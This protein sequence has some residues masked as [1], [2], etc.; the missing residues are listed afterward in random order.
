MSRTRALAATLAL[1]CAAPLAGEAQAWPFG[2]KADKPATEQP[3]AA[4]PDKTSR[5][6]GVYAGEPASPPSTPRKASPEE[7]AAAARLDP[8][9]QAAFWAREMQV[10]PADADAGVRLSAALRSLG[11]H[12]GAAST[13]EQVLAARPGHAPAL[14]ELARAKLAANQGF[15][16]I[17]PLRQIRAQAPT[18]W[19]ALNLLGVAM[20]QAQRMGEAR[21]AWAEALR[22]SP[23]NPQVLTNM[24]LADMAEGRA[25]QAE[26]TLR[27][28]AAR[29][30]A[31]VRVRQNLALV[32]GLRGRMAEAEAMLRQDLPPE[33]VAQNLAWLRTR[34]GAAPR[35]WGTLQGGG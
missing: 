15:Y 11:Q 18:D 29:P 8:L 2:R 34:S 13:A 21:A 12:D 16:A 27:R 14:Y 30:D 24:A 3:T 17:E 20:Q 19:R 1:A 28:A 6:G 4:K 25:D 5:T 26:A 31:D 9:A 10:D 33:V 7:R 35:T 32:L 23:E 22:L